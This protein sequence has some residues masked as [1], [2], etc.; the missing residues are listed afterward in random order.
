[1]LCCN[2]PWGLTRHLLGPSILS[3]LLTAFGHSSQER[4][5][6]QFRCLTLKWTSLRKSIP[7]LNLLPGNS[8]QISDRAPEGDLSSWQ[9]Y[10]WAEWS[11]TPPGR[12]SNK[13]SGKSK[14]LLK[15]LFSVMFCFVWFF[16]FEHD[17]LLKLTADFSPAWTDWGNP[18]GKTVLLPNSNY[19]QPGLK[20]EIWTWCQ[21]LCDLL[22]RTIDLFL[23]NTVLSYHC[24]CCSPVPG[25]P[26]SLVVHGHSNWKT[27]SI[28]EK[29][30]KNPL[31]Q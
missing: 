24:L 21:S 18:G 12:T 1:M 17:K 15:S 6:V 23:W 5:Q 30:S 3:L 25:N 28:G 27:D 7:A 14:D 29:A 22:V 8:L 9:M 26:A 11:T 10:I 13:L 2:T 16:R 31:C 4:P 19:L 20:S